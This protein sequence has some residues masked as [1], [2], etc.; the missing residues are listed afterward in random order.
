MGKGN[1]S[2]LF[3]IPILQ[4][5]INRSF[6]LPLNDVLHGVTVLGGHRQTR[7]KRGNGSIGAKNENI[8][9]GPIGKYSQLPDNWMVGASRK[10]HGLKMIR[11]L[12]SFLLLFQ[13]FRMRFLNSTD[14]ITQDDE[15]LLDILGRAF[16]DKGTVAGNMGLV[17]HPA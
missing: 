14:I 11:R 1:L 17:Q 10:E 7:K 8:G 3:E 15:K 5:F 2:G 12:P 6:I 13:S 4:S 9:F 16:F